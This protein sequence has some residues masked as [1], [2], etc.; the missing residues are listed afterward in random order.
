[1]YRGLGDVFSALHC[2]Q[3][4]A[5]WAAATAPRRLPGCSPP[6]GPSAP[7]GGCQNPR[8]T[9]SSS[10]ET[11]SRLLATLG[12]DGVAEQSR[13]GADLDLDAAMTLADE[14]LGNP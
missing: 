8:P 5:A 4:V 6:Y 12:P 9:T 11:R 7:T 1:M 14:L 10:D 3:H 2:L 13:L